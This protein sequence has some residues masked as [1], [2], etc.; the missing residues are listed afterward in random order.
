[1]REGERFREN[2]NTTPATAGPLPV[3]P[4]APLSHPHHTSSPAVGACGQADPRD[5]A[6]LSAGNADYWDQLLQSRRSF[7]GPPPRA[8][9]PPPLII[10]IK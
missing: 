4:P 1:M 10:W 8:F 9:L 7:R 6:I 2:L 3:L 5:Q